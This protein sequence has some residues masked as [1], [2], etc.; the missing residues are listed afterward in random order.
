MTDA[1]PVIERGTAETHGDHHLLRFT[2]RLP[3]PVP[4]VWAAV[5]SSEGLRGWL[6]AADPF[7][8]RIGGAI[9]LR[10]LNTD[11]DGN[12][13]VASGTVTAWDVERVAEYTL[14]GVH[15]RI[16]FHLEPPRGEHVLLR[17]S[18]E[19]HGDDA[20]RL[21]CLAGWHNHFE[22]LMDALDGHPADW[23]RWTPARWRELRESYG[24]ED[25]GK[26]F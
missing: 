26:Q 1:L 6:A 17:F 11:P 21:D 24:A 13:T 12:A 25:G 2:L 18:N 19:F 14:E 23:S 5:A 4:R 9:T 15:G 8:P 10:W 3:Y 16:R 7:E 22:Y 20:L